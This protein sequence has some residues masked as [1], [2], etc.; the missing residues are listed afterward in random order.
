M[1]NKGKRTSDLCA[2]A[3]LVTGAPFETIENKEV[4]HPMWDGKVDDEVNAQFIKAAAD[5][6]W[7]NE[8]VRMYIFPCA[9][10][11]IFCLE[12]SECS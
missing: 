9:C 11:L 4:W 5:R 10:V 7:E 2:V 8:Q 12:D 6:I 1:G 3:P